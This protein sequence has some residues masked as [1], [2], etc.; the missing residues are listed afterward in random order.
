[1]F[2]MAVGAARPLLGGQD[3]PRGAPPVTDD[4]KATLF[5]LHK[6]ALQGNAPS[7][8]TDGIPDGMSLLSAAWRGCAGMRRRDAM[9]AFVGCLDRVAPWW[10]AAAAQGRDS[11]GHRLNSGHST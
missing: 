8:S 7:M 10:R 3:A 11:S 4:D 5:G 9:R 1:M 2:R 6:Q